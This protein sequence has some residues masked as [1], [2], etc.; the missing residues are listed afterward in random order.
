MCFF[1]MYHLVVS[2]QQWDINDCRCL[3]WGYGP[4]KHAEGNTYCVH[5]QLHFSTVYFLLFKCYDYTK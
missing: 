2:I 1:S 5:L 4:V 3:V